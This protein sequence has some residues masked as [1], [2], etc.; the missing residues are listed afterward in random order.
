MMVI[1]TPT[2]EN[3]IEVL[4]W[5]LEDM[6]WG[7]DKSKLIHKDYWET[8]RS[9]TCVSIINEEITYCS[10][11]FVTTRLREDIHVLDMTQFYKF[12]RVDSINKFKKKFDL[13]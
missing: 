11:E 4:E 8:Y 9:E 2:L 5:A 6:V 12:A 1:N 10:K 13:R 7:G 3:Y